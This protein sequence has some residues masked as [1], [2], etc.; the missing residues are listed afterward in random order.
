[1]D[2]HKMK[3]SLNKEVV[4]NG[5]IYLFT[6]CIFRLDENGALRCQAELKDRLANSVLICRLEDVEEKSDSIA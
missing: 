5:K 3:D 4:Y 6:A 1:M 2:K